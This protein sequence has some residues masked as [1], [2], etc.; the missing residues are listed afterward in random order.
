MSFF[1]Q[2]IKE[3]DELPRKYA[4]VNQDGLLFLIDLEKQEANV[5]KDRSSRSDILVPRSV[6]YK[7]REY[8][9]T[10]ISEKAFAKS[11]QLKSLQFSS[12]SELRLIE[13]DAFMLSSIQSLTIPSSLIELNTNWCKATTNLTEIKIMPNNQRFKL[14]DN[15]CIIAK[16]TPESENYDILVF[17]CRDIESFTIPSFI[18]HIAPSAFYYCRNLKQITIPNDSELQTIGD[19][20]FQFSSIERF[21]I[22]PTVIEISEEAFSNCAI[23]SFEIPSNSQLKTIG[24]SCFRDSFI[25]S[26][27]IPSHVTQIGELALTCNM[28]KT[29]DFAEDCELEE[30][31]KNVFYDSNIERIT[32]PSNVVVLKDGWCERTKNLTSVSVMPNNKRYKTY[33]DKYIIGKSSQESEDFDLLV[34]ARRDIETAIIPSFITQICPFA[35]NNC[36]KLVRV[37]IP[38]ESKLE[39]IDENAFTD[40]SIESIVIPPNLAELRSG[41]CNS[42][43]NLTK[44][45]V[46]PNNHHFICLDNKVVLG[47]SKKKSDDYDVLVFARRDIEAF[48]VP[49]FIKRIDRC[50]FQS[51]TK[52]KNVHFSDDSQLKSIENNAFESVSI[53][54]ISIPHHVT[55]IGECAFVSTAEL[56]S[57]DI[58]IDSELQI[59]DH[60]AF[61]ESSIERIFI[62]PLVE[63]IGYGSFSC[64]RLRKVDML[65]NSNLR[66][67][68]N[69]AFM[70]TSIETFNLPCHVTHIGSAAFS[71]TYNLKKFEI[72]QN[73]ELKIIGENAFS[74]SSLPSIFIPSH[75]TQFNGDIFYKCRNLQ[76]VEISDDLDLKVIDKGL[77]NVSKSLIIMIPHNCSA[78]LI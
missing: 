18:K 30:L 20:A 54:S 29:V 64:D 38:V 15:K 16:S 41:W 17:A 75:L 67:I 46:M 28:L 35:F 14:L 72:T 45:E 13:K 56:R 61:S 42:T 5:L 31:D 63:R 71:S 68:D 53:K 76:I 8:I 4:K 19:Y 49:S 62:P 21:T 70:S 57:V 33:K 60:H 10:S 77:F 11:S 39:I 34:F 74:C 55:Y 73:S 47:K 37:E 24:K 69:Y 22:P 58:P 48:T 36:S 9:I 65:P 40:S 23:C 66:V 78:H 12:D 52:L 51:C 27:F 26:I 32:I 25:E 50:A 59:I 43:P 1:E 7:S 2:I 3:N 44:I 6:Y